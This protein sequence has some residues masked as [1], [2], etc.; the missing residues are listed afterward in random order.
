M[1]PRILDWRLKD[2]DEDD[3]GDGEGNWRIEFIGRR[4][5]ESCLEQV[6]FD[7]STSGVLELLMNSQ[8]Y[9]SG[10]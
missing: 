9:N 5:Q 10:V 2:E 7:M 8:V 1:I 3:D 6:K 4:A